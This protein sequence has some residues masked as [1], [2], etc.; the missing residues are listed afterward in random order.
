MIYWYFIVEGRTEEE[1]VKEILKPFLE[2]KQ[3]FV[4]GVEQVITGRTHIGK[5]CKGGG[6]NYEYYKN[7]LLKRMKQFKKRDDLYFTTMLDLYALPKTFPNYETYIDEKD[8]YKKVDALEKAFKN[9]I[10]QN[11]FIPYIQLHEFETLLFSDLNKFK[12]YY[13]DED[14]IDQKVLALKSDVKGYDN[15][16][17]INES[18][19]TAPSKRI[20]NFFSQYCSEKATVGLYVA[21]EIGLDKMRKECKHFNEWIKKLE[22]LTQ[23][24]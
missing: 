2:T 9:D 16:E 14:N 20:E 1:F 24:T 6:N 18:E 8:K 12:E 10:K 7:H 11:N 17:L 13:I 15:I 5:Y 23:K 22:N 21:L 4:Q 19:S 3:I